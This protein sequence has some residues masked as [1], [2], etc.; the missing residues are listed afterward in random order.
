MRWFN[1]VLV[2]FFVA[3][4]PL[5]APAETMMYVNGWSGTGV[6]SYNISAVAT[7][8]GVS[9]FAAGMDGREGWPSTVRATCT[10]SI[11]ATL[12]LFPARSQRSLR[13]VLA[14][15]RLGAV[16]HRQLGL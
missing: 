10:Y 15:N 7:D 3:F 5:L 14:A 12:T 11:L 1:I 8:G 4:T 2:V 16:W 13:K 6:G 9:T